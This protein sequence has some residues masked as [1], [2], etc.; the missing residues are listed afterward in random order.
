MKVTVQL[1]QSSPRLFLNGPEIAQ[2][3]KFS[4]GAYSAP[5]TP[6]CMGLASLVVMDATFQTFFSQA[7]LIPEW[8]NSETELETAKRSWNHRNG[9][10][11]QQYQLYSIIYSC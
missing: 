7:T 1:Q 6:S 4:W 9:A 11:N 2:N 5:H 10:E 8:G 3:S